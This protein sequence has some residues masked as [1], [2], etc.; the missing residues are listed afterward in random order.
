MTTDE[1][2]LV[3]S[4]LQAAGVVTRRRPGTRAEFLRALETT[5]DTTLLHLATHGLPRQVG[6]SRGG[7]IRG[8]LLFSPDDE[9]EAKT[10][11]TTEELLESK[12]SLDHLQLVVLSAC[13]TADGEDV[14]LDG[15]IGLCQA[16]LMRGVRAVIAASWELE[17]A[18]CALFM[19]EFYRALVAQASAT[20]ALRAARVFFINH[21]EWGHPRYWAGFTLHGL[22]VKF[23]FRR[24]PINTSIPE[25]EP[26]IRADAVSAATRGRPECVP[27]ADLLPQ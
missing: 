8:A 24:D 9:S 21:S 3:S 27:S 2:E 17:D 10:V 6:L 25:A 20:D 7:P 15:R 1:G 14:G 18:F 16:L 22:D 13:A 26:V 5:Q 23:S 11:L 19:R 4:L 12:G